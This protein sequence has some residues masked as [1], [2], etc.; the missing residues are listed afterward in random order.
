M[1]N[2]RDKRVHIFNTFVLRNNTFIRYQLFVDL[3]IAT[4]FIILFSNIFAVYTVVVKE[5]V[6]ETF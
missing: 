3:A 4:Y 1:R 5:M 2:L 6:P